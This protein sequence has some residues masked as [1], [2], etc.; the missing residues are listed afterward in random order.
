MKAKY[1]LLIFG[2]INI[3]FLCIV[4]LNRRGYSDTWILQDIFLPT[5]IY[6]LAFVIVAVNT[7]DNRILVFVCAAFLMTL[8]AIPNLKYELF[9]GTFDSVAHYG[10]AN[11]I[12]STGF[13]QNYGFYASTYFDFPGMHIFLSAISLVLG[14]DLVTTMGLIT[15]VIYGI[16]PF[17]FYFATNGVFDKKIQKYIIISSGLPTTLMS[18]ALSGSTFGILFFIAFFC[19]FLKR[20]LCNINDKAYT[21]V[22]LVLAFGLLFTHATTIISLVLLLAL[23]LILMKTLAFVRKNH[24][25]SSYVRASLGVFVV[26]SVSLMAWLDLKAGSIFQFFVQ[27][28]Q[29]YLVRNVVNAPVPS[30]FFEIPL[31]DKL[32][33]LAMIYA[34]T[35][36]FL[37][38]MV[39]GLLVLLKKRPFRNSHLSEKLYLPL[40]CLLGGMLLFAGFDSLT[41]RTEYIR[42]VYYA[43]ALSP[44]LVG[45]FLWST[46]Q[47][48]RNIRKKT[49]IKSFILFAVIFSIISISLIQTFPFQP[50]TPTANDISKNLPAN[51]YIFDFSEVNT[52]YQVD[53]IHFAGK[54]SPADAIV[55]SDIVTRWQIAGFANSAFYN[56]TL[57]D[58]PLDTNLTALGSKWDICLLH[59][60]G[61]SGPL[62]EYVANRTRAAVDEFRTTAGSTVYD[63]GESFIICR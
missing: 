56:R 31:I 15:S 9:Q 57:W 49:W 63:N 26:I 41:G 18:F 20:N 37:V 29:S 22:L 10:F 61:R 55:A 39:A 45:L 7:D 11:Q 52:M 40:I 28:A 51:E 36:V 21:L 33:I 44:F 23:M 14:I 50:M 53:M 59:Y 62:N 6:I 58:S 5:I 16:I 4:S 25:V 2:I 32:K 43:L 34:R 24:S 12:L 19:V 60:D 42:F 47:H 17:L 8:N 35:A 3:V 48:F 54:F 46:D 13:V 27:V 1:L 38:L 30:T